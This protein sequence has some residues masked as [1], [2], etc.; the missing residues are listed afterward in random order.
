MHFQQLPKC[1]QAAC[2]EIQRV[3]QRRTIRGALL[4]WRMETARLEM[5]EECERDRVALIIAVWEAADKG[6][7]ESTNSALNPRVTRGKVSTSIIGQTTC[8][9]VQNAMGIS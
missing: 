8:Q 6:L 1:L 5:E 4:A 7:M 3:N 9:H 2:E